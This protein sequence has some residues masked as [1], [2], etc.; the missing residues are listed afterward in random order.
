MKKSLTRQI[1]FAIIILV[2]GTI[3]ALFVVNTTFLSKYYVFEKRNL[4]MESFDTLQTASE[5]GTLYSSDFN[6][7]FEAMCS[8][9]NISVVIMEPNGRVA[10]TSVYDFST[11]QRQLYDVMIAGAN[12]PRRVLYSSDN[13]VVE[14]MADSMMNDAEYLMLWGT[15]SDGN[16][17]LVRT[18]MESIRES[19]II[20]NKFLLYVGICALAVSMLISFGMS[21]RI[22]KPV[23]QLT[24]ISKKMV[25][26]D[27]DAKYVSPKKKPF[28]RKKADVSQNRI[29]IS[30]QN[31]LDQLGEHMNQLSSTLEKTISE[32]K[33]ANNQLMQ[34]IEKKEQI[35]EMRKEF[36]SNVSHE[37]KTPL[38]LIQGY[39]EG[40]SECINHDQESRNYY[41]EVIIDEADKM[42]QMV[43][44]LLTLNQLEF[45]N[46]QVTMERFNIT[47]LIH[48][49]VNASSILLKQKEITVEMDLPTEHVW[50]DEFK[51]E[52][53]LTNF[54]SNAINH[55]EFE[56]KIRI[57]YEKK[58]TCLRI[59]VFNT[60][61][62]IPQEDLEN[63]W[64][65][66]YKVDKARTREYGGSGIGLSIVK[67]IMDSF[68]QQCGVINHEDGVEFWFELGL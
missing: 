16:A 49:V 25:A 58:E 43:K 34:D 12:K 46:D 13:F 56:K 42:N 51:V 33:T 48:G 65:K 27:F 11:I 31:E 28:F 39:A 38:A 2:V 59:S 63:I 7:D 66:F 37:L 44:K 60:G 45:G 64:I 17:I 53:V 6:D 32:L 30:E 8:S 22:T 36:L 5:N 4:L 23:L 26:L 68:H 52:E 3:V 47:E 54:L 50:A 19:S 20:A 55:A 67:A 62:P 57:F 14:H 41:C 10:R 35:D 24:E 9:Q 15:L 1:M 40:L 29:P 61:K 18:D 21:R